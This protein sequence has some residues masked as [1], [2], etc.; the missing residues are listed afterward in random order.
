[1]SGSTQY[2]KYKKIVR[3]FHEIYDIVLEK[4]LS[5]L[6]CHKCH[7]LGEVIPSIL[8][9]ASTRKSLLP[10][11]LKM[12]SISYLL[13]NG[14]LPIILSPLFAQRLTCSGFPMHMG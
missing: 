4:G 3:W 12:A 13:Y 2:S 5:G 8:A 7:P 9:V 6:D 10:G 14:S 11:A 1:M